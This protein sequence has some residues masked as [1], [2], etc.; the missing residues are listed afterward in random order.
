MLL[1]LFF[2]I[3]KVVSITHCLV[4]WLLGGVTIWGFHVVVQ[5]NS[6]AQYF[7]FPGS[8]FCSLRMHSNIIP[9]PAGEEVAVVSPQLNQ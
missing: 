6:V 7:L 9:V 8:Y 3:V 5:L 2:F 4:P 1:L